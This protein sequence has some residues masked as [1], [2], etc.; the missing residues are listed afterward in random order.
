MHDGA[1]FFY[2]NCD[3]NDKLIGNKT[4]IIVGPACMVHGDNEY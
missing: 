3:R 1:L 2:F 4:T